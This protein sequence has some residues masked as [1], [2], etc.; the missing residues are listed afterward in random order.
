VLTSAFE[1]TEVD[2]DRLA[3]DK[4]RRL[5]P[6]ER[7][8]PAQRVSPQ[9]ELPADQVPFYPSTRARPAG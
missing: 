6:I 5:P 9:E 4:V 8:F 2:R 3:Q 1:V 7:V